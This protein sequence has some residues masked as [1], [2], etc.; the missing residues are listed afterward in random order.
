[1]PLS[2]FFRIIYSYSYIYLYLYAHS[3]EFIV[4]AKCDCVA[5]WI[6]SIGRSNT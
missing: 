5:E 2:I 1:M 3:S 6:F 4:H